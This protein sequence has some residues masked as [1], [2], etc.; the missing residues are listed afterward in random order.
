MFYDHNAEWDPSFGTPR[1]LCV[2][3]VDKNLLSYA[4]LLFGMDGY[5]ESVAKLVN[6]IHV[7]TEATWKA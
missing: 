5:D 6:I 1:I 4:K 3:H 7:Q 2:W